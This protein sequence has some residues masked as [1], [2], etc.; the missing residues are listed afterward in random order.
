MIKI[1][2]QYPV[3]NG[4][5]QVPP[6]NP[7]DKT[8]YIVGNR[9]RNPVGLS[10]AS[11]KG[12][13]GNGTGWNKVQSGA[14]APVVASDV[15]QITSVGVSSTKNAFWD[16]AKI[17]TGKS[18]KISFTYRCAQSSSQA[19]GITFTVHNDPDG[20]A[21]V[22]SAGAG[23]GYVGLRNSFGY[24][25]NVDSG[26]TGTYGGTGLST[27]GA[28]FSYRN[29]LIS[30]P[31][32][33]RDTRAKNITIE[34]DADA[35]SFIET[36]VDAVNGNTYTR[37]F[38]GI[39]LNS[40]IGTDQAYYGFTGATSSSKADQFISNFNVVI[41]AFNSPDSDSIKDAVIKRNTE[42]LEFLTATV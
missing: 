38:T 2:R 23:L 30:D 12:F 36:I 11:L 18:F 24:A 35:S 1:Y 22:G 6:N 31:V 19:D 25:I 3:I 21:A 29:F 42:Y 16:T 41:N 28:A 9:R 20:L 13:N 32:N 8:K 10:L 40:I 17:Y 39:N 27:G 34:Y 15:L 5:L 7:A 37:T 14:F 26:T 4:F 33:L